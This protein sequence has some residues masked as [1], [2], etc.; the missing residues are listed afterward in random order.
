MTRN[1]AHLP[2][3]V[4]FGTRKMLKIT[5]SMTCTITF[6]RKVKN[7]W[8]SGHVQVWEIEIEILFFFFIKG[9]AHDV[10][11]KLGGGGEG[12]RRVSFPVIQTKK[13]H[14]FRWTSFIAFIYCFSNY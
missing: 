8:V 4:F 5:K 6:R 1:A 2:K 13:T 12:M 7:F 9:I 10:I 11:Q 14:Q 3:P